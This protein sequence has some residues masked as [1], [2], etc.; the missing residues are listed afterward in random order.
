MIKQHIYRRDR[1]GYRT[2]AASAGLRDSA[3][4]SL[5]EQQTVLR[6]QSNAPAPVYYQ[7]P[8]GYGLVLSRCAV[9]PN[10]SH[11][12]YLVHQLVADEPGDIEALTAL[13]PLSPANFRAAYVG[14]EGE[15]EPLP[16]LKPESLADPAQ[17]SAGFRLIDAWFD[18]AR[19]ARLIA[20]LFQAARDKRC[21]IH[22][23]IDQEPAQVSEQGRLLMDMLM[24]ALPVQEVQRI[25]YCTF[26]A[27]SETA[28]P[29]SV[30]ISRPEEDEEGVVSAATARC[31]RFDM[32]TG[33]DVW[34]DTAPE[35]D[36]RSL[37][38]ARALLA[39]DV[40]WLDRVRLGGA[41]ARLG[42]SA[43]KLDIPAFERGMSLTQYVEDWLEALEERRDALNGEAFQVFA[44]DE[45]PRLT[46][47][48]IRA[49]DLMDSA[50]FVSQL[51]AGIVALCRGKRGEQLGMSRQNLC[52]L[53]VILLDGIRW[54][55]V[56]LYDPDTVR[57]MR[58]A[59]GYVN[60]LGDT[61]CD[62]GC[63]LACRVVHALLDAPSTHLS[64]ALDDMVQLSEEY[65]ALFAQVQACARRY[66]ASRCRAAREGFE[67]FGLVDDMF[68]AAAMLG[69]VR[70]EGGI[71]DFRQL[72]K[73]QE[74]VG[75]IAGDRTGQ[76]F[77]ARLER[78]RRRMH[79]SRVN[80]ARQ[81]EMRF[82]LIV[83]L[84]LAL[85]IAGVI[86]AYF[87]FIRK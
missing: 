69:Y 70:F 35:T 59:T 75:Q 65:P 51:H 11:G 41:Q 53:I 56:D 46:E 71:P 76:R 49:A 8:L 87:V 24:R 39:H 62:R 57:M 28:M 84:L 23:V 32:K 13:R 45:W 50:D 20:G 10:G 47:R 38:L 2:V 40:N 52:D 42:A 17:L 60:L 37:Q 74:K 26:M 6:C 86:I 15:V 27:P 18:E 66:V 85:V 36:E 55:D 67:E 12:S 25:S 58:S 4:L 14:R 1:T 72:E 3:W 7:Y 30:F 9:D 5:L 43:V 78:I 21:A 22:I 48:V 80:L 33:R 73:V 83:S 34:P 31:A 64:E 61:P 44:R 54:D 82:M 79:A 16:T 68:M 19:L 77:E 29:Y 63:L 81:R